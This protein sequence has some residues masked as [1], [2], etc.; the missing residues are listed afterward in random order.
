MTDFQATYDRIL[1][2][3][4]SRYRD[5]EAES[6]ANVVIALCLRTGRAENLEKYVKTAV[7]R[8]MFRR[9]KKCENLIFDPVARADYVELFLEDLDE[10]QKI[11]YDLKF[12]QQ[13]SYAEIAE[14]LGLSINTVISRV[15]LLKRKIVDEI[16]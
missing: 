12:K 3:V 11:L 16:G 15:N 6:F 1:S 10:H 9:S 5:D 2:W 13:F 4:R 8:H 14:L 7:R